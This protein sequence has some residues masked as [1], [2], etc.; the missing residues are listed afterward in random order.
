MGRGSQGQERTCPVRGGERSR[1]KAV[2]CVRVGLSRRQPGWGEAVVEGGWAEE[3]GLRLRAEP[4]APV[5]PTDDGRDAGGVGVLGGGLGHPCCTAEKWPVTRGQ[6]RLLV[7]LASAGSVVR[8]G[9]EPRGGTT[10]GVGCSGNR[11][12]R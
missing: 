9:R 4:G 7:A 1:G 3:Q 10:Q 6:W 11:V 12:G 5:A 2:H 8:W